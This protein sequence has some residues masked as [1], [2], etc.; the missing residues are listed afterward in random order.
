MVT[1]AE[2]PAVRARGGLGLG[3]GDAV[4]LIIR[5]GLG[6]RVIAVVGDLDDVAGRLS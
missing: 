2:S 1:I 6:A 4:Q 5:E 3:A